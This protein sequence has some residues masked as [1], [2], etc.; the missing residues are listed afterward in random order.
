MYKYYELYKNSKDPIPLRIT[1]VREAK[2]IGIKP[3]ARKCKTSPK[4]VR[5]WVKR[6]DEE[7]KPGLQDRSRRPKSSP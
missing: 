7:K 5:K 1:I 6:F 2:K 3:T 4:T